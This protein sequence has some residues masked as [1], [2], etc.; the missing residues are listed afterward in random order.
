[1]EYMSTEG[2]VRS[3][4]EYQQSCTVTADVAQLQISDAT[5]YQRGKKPDKKT[6]IKANKTDD[7]SSP[8]EVELSAKT[9][10]TNKPEAD[11]NDDKLSCTDHIV[12]A[13]SAGS[14][15]RVSD[16]T[17]KKP[18]CTPTLSAIASSVSDAAEKENVK[19]REDLESEIKSF[20]VK[21]GKEKLAFPPSLSSQER[22]YVHS[23]AEELGVEHESK[24][25]GDQRYIVVRKR[26][27]K[28]G[29]K[30]K[31]VIQNENENQLSE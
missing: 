20:L 29:E 22:F 1:M 13:A 28:R 3:A 4:L 9:S 17:A 8:A 7:S 2:E 12:K 25:E 21:K 5:F 11:T 16:R 24:G 27:E 14:K 6:E 18:D 10:T 19:S 15:P 23:I 31:R 30:G 26:S